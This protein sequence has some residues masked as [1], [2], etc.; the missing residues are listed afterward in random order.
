MMPPYSMPAMDSEPP[1]EGD[2]VTRGVALP[3]D[4]DY[5]VTESAAVE[6]LRSVFDPEIPVN[7]YDLGLIYDLSISERGN[8]DVVM[9]L[10]APAC[11]V[12]GTLPGEVADAVA[13]TKGA[14]EVTVK[15][16]WDPPWTPENMS[17]VARVAL[18]MF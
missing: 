18:D 11:P 16:T 4:A 6:A 8:V 3:E 12:A 2:V 7:I 9:T 5:V 10:T 1:E 15:I 17:E 14:G 13:E